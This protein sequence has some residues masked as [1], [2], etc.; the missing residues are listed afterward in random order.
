MSKFD[1]MALKPEI[2][3]ALNESGYER[4]MMIQERAIPIAMEGKD[5]IGCAQT[6]TGKTAAFA[7]PIL[8]R[9]SE[10]RR[11]Q[12]L[13]LAP[14]RELAIQIGDS[15]EKY[16]KYLSIRTATIY[17]GVPYDRQI[18]ALRRGSDVIVATPGRLIDHVKRGNV[19]LK[20]VRY[21]V[22]DEA[23]RMLDMGF[24]P[25]IS[26][27]IQYVP[28]R[29]QTML[30][31]ATMP[32]EIRRLANRYMK[33]EVRIDAAP[34]STVAKGITHRVYAV[35]RSLKSR[36]VG[37]LIEDEPI[38]SVLVF[39][40]TRKGADRL[41]GY[42]TRKNLSVTSLHSDRTQGQRQ[43]ALKGFRDGKFK[44]LVATD[45]AARGLDIPTVSHVFN[46]D[47]PEN[48]DDYVHRAG[49]TAR[50]DATGFSFCI[51]APEDIDLF[52]TLEQQVGKETFTWSSHPG[53]D[54]LDEPKD[55]HRADHDRRGRGGVNR[56][57]R[58][59]R[60]AVAESRSPR[61]SPAGPPAAPKSSTPK[62]PFGRKKSKSSGRR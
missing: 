51:V 37:K 35:P 7:L 21:L 42:L 3:K 44:I 36:L 62:K 43:A 52:N 8:H 50:A 17:G 28:A 1:D 18:R 26:Q 53:F 6:G 22:L 14:T 33:D 10:G 9:I 11:P 29:E 4:P 2:L 27:I 60:A 19:S 49:R 25:D 31:S 39:T 20:P 24:L 56:T 54:Y 47:L 13:I 45:I 58:G 40:R 34:P 32:P 57:G 16:G 41:A 46:F 5:L 59:G 23:D 48:A 38:Q 61:K 15:F 12:A 55:S 30:F